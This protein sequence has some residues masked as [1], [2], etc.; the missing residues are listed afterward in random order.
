ML[1]SF[2]RNAP[3]EKI[4]PVLER[5]GAVIVRD[6]AAPELVDQLLA[7]F[8]PDLLAE[9]WCNLSEGDDATGAA[10]FGAKTKRLRGLLARSPAFPELV[11]QPTML[12][13]CERLLRPNCRDLRL[14]IGE[15][16]ALGPGQ[17]RQYLHRDA[18]SW[19]KIPEPRPEVLLSANVALTAF[20]EANGATVVV[21]GSH[22]WPRDRKPTDD[23]LTL[24]VMPRGAALVYS[25]WVIHGGGAN[26][27]EEVRIGCYLGLL[28]SWLRP[29]ENHLIT[30]GL[31][32]VRA[33]P[34]DVQRL[35]D[36]TE[37]GFTVLA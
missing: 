13:L 4:A 18:D 16:I 21:P 17:A 32:V 3:A 35:L 25:G 7:D 37:A 33:A 19:Y 14:S 15:L 8:G 10:F 24:A 9:P 23:E 30:N 2:D 5:D 20:T 6:F 34:P 26:R 28:A 1:E 11:T 31:D 36:Y 12:A 27:T 22:R 29:I